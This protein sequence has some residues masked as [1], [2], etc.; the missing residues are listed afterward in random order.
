MARGHNLRGS[1]PLNF[2]TGEC[3]G[4]WVQ[5]ETNNTDAPDGIIQASDGVTIA[6]AD[7]GDFTI[8]FPTNARPAALLYGTADF[9]E[10]LA[11]YSAKVTGYTASTGVLT[12]ST[13]LDDGSP[14][15]A[16]TTDKTV[17]VFCIF[18]R[19]TANS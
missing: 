2:I 12:L 19:K 1:F 13:Y 9:I 16:D 7:V 18:S 8:T 6:R 15:V 3:F 11:D 4:Y 5:F 14:A 10:D 17:S